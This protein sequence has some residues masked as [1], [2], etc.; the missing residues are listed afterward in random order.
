MSTS[1]KESDRRY[2]ASEKG[3]ARRRKYDASEAG[4]ARH[5][6]YNHTENGRARHHHWY[7]ENYLAIIM[8][9]GRLRREKAIAEDGGF[10]WLPTPPLIAGTAG[11][12]LP[13]HSAS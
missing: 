11:R 2:D 8:R 4:R 3:K 5:R 10:S 6:R 13:T 7:C 9:R 1:R 12:Q